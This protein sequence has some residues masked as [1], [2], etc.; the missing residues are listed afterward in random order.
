MCGTHSKCVI[1]QVE[2]WYLGFCLSQTDKTQHQRVGEAV[3]EA[4]W[5]LLKFWALDI[6]NPLTDLTNKGRGMGAVLYQEVEGKELYLLYISHKLSVKETKNSMNKS[7]VWPSSEWSLHSSTTYW[8]G[9]LVPITP[10]SNG[11]TAWRMPLQGSLVGMWHFSYSN[12]QAGGADGGGRLPLTVIWLYIWSCKL[13]L[14][15]KQDLYLE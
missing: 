12:S 4:C 5:I 2:E 9:P 6:T 10:H 13:L 8:G 11:S 14:M 1:G 15:Y 3:P 7:S